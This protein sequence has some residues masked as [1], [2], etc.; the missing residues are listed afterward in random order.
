MT[1][2]DILVS[3]QVSQ[4]ERA[5]FLDVFGKRIAEE[6]AESVRYAACWGPEPGLLAKLPSLEVIF[7]LGAGVDH[8]LRDPDLPDVPIVRFVDPD[9]TGRMVEYVVLQCLMHLRRQR[10][11][12]DSQKARRW[13]PRAMPTASEMTVGILGFGNLGQACGKALQAVGFQVRGLNR[14]KRHVLGF[15][16]FGSGQMAAFLEG[17][18]MLVNLM[19]YTPQTDGMLN[20]HLIDG[21][22]RDG[23]LIAPVLINAGRGGSQ[24]ED[25]IV[26]ALQEGRL[27]GVSLDVFRTEPLPEH[28]PLWG[29][30]GA[31]ITPHVAAV[32]SPKAMARYVATQ[33][34][35]L[36]V[37]QRLENVVDRDLGY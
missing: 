12:D 18:D 15:E 11:Y 26:T 24:D 25:D 30:P 29:A 34:D 17:S 3:G 32:T 5:A 19:P 6:P 22:R 16:T 10:D 35:R 27:S 14:S 23:P 31:I 33:L 20:T 21:L 13:E 28:S 37:G 36:A 7:S 1:K 8:L 4:A 9:L 2:L